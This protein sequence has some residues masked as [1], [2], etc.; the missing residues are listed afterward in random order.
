M[1]ERVVADPTTS[2]IL[3]VPDLAF[4]SRSPCPD[5]PARIR[6]SSSSG[7]WSFSPGTRS[8]ERGSTTRLE[9]QKRAADEVGVER[10]GEADATMYRIGLMSKL[11]GRDDPGEEGREGEGW[12]EGSRSL[13]RLG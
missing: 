12:W 7:R 1:D 8:T 13:R 3:L 2:T 10:V 9:E 6:T 4:R 11:Q 5:P